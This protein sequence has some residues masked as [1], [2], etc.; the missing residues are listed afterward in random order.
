MVAV[1]TL[2]LDAP[3]HLHTLGHLGLIYRATAVFVIG[4]LLSLKDAVGVGREAPG[5]SAQTRGGPRLPV[6]PGRVRK[7]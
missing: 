5:R 4:A 1:N 6:L 7:G 2:E 3:Y